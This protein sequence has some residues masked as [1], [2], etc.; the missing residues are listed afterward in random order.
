MPREMVL[1]KP[2]EGTEEDRDQRCDQETSGDQLRGAVRAS[3]ETDRTTASVLASLRASS[4][5]LCP[6]A[7]GLW[8]LLEH[9]TGLHRS[10]EL[11]R[12]RATGTGSGR[13]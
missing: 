8:V 4:T 7:G 9:S 2:R 11:A 5:L 12:P 10:P 3:R 1:P 6:F 13:V